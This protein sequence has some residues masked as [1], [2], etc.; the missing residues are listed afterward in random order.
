M[1]ILCDNINL[2]TNSLF[3]LNKMVLV[4][5]NRSFKKTLLVFINFL[6]FI[7]YPIFFNN[8]NANTFP[9]NQKIKKDFV[10]HEVIGDQY[11]LGVGDI[12]IFKINQLPGSSNRIFIGPDGFI[13]LEEIEPI[14]A[15]GLTLKELKELISNR[16]S[17]ILYDPDIKL[18][19]SSYRPVNVYVYG[20]V[21]RPGI[22]TLSGQSEDFLKNNQEILLDTQ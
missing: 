13:N 6:F 10:N 14:Y 4:N 2:C 8:I 11:L 5:I 19:L 7:F 17:E 9:N 18:F 12:L 15:V 21:E 3:L 16:Y 1:S 22:Y 20:E